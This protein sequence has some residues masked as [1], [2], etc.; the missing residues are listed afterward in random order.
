MKI[1][2]SIGDPLGVSVGSAGLVT[3]VNQ[4]PRNGTCNAWPP[5]GYSASTI[6]TLNCI[7]WTDQD[8]EDEAGGGTISRYFFYGTSLLISKLSLNIC[9]SWFLV[10]FDC[11]K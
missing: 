6:F 10:L 8:E 2:L 11:T 5:Q 1:V 3:Q 4:P 7:D 9:M